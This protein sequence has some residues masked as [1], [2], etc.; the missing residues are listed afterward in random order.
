MQEIDALELELG[1]FLRGAF[2]M[3]ADTATV[4][5]GFVMRAWTW[6]DNQR[7]NNSAPPVLCIRGL[8]GAGKTEL[9]NR[10]G[11]VCPAEL[12]IFDDV[13]YGDIPNG[14]KPC[15]PMIFIV[16]SGLSF[17]ASEIFQNPLVIDMPV[18]P[19]REVMLAGVSLYITPQIVSRAEQLKAHMRALRI[20]QVV[21]CQS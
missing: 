15:C 13:I 3:D 16:R 5:T 9:S 1:T 21:E 11:W 18:R 12:I 2:L 10:I 4:V 14:F 7:D 17:P 6:R 19:V 8:E 20:K